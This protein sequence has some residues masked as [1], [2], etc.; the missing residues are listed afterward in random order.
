MKTLGTPASFF[1]SAASRSAGLLACT[2]ALALTLSAC[3]SSNQDE[4]SAAPASSSASTSAASASASTS[5]A[6]SSSS[7]SASTS[8]TAEASQASEED[9]AAQEALVETNPAAQALASASQVALDAPEVNTT[10]DLYTGVQDIFSTIE[11]VIQED[12]PVDSGD[13]IV[14]NSEDLAAEN[15]TPRDYISAE[16]VSALEAKASDS[17]L[18]QY[19]ATATEYALSGWKVEGSSTVVG[20]PRLADGQYK[21]KAAKILEVC[22]DS[23]NVKILDENGN[24][25]PTSGPTRS[26]NIFTLVED[27][28]TWK[29][30]AHDFPNDADC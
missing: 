28:G 17:A 15:Q 24:Q 2:A 4:S 14:S 13:E 22:L 18:D 11:P 19:L 27:Q 12:I 30:A 1:S 25:V 7:A 6:S 21:D 20:T 10:K 8:A 26:L 3:G 5:Q 9:Q 16:A 23:S 29:I